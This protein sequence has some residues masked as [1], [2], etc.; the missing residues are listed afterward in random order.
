MVCATSSRLLVG[1]GGGRGVVDL[2]AGALGHP[3]AELQH[4]AP[5][6]GGHL[7]AVLAV[8]QM[9][10][11]GYVLEP[12]GEEGARVF[13]A[14]RVA[15]AVL[16]L[17]DLAAELHQPL[18][19]AFGHHGRQHGV[20]QRAEHA[21]LVLR[22]ELAQ[23]A[24]R[25]VAHAALRRGDGAQKGR[26]VVVVDPQAKP[27]AQ[28]ADLGAVK[29]R[30]AARDLVGDVGLAQRLLERLGLVVGAV[31]DGEV[32]PGRRRV[33][34]G[35]Q[36]LDARHGAL[37]LVLLVVA[38][39]HAHRLALAQFAEQRLG[40]QLGVRPDDVVGRAQ[41]GRGGAVVLLQ[42]D[43][44]ELRKVLRQLLQ[45]VQRGAAPA[46]DALVVVAHGGEARAFAH[47]EFQQLVL[48][49]VGVLVFI[50]QHM[51]QQ[52]LPFLAHLGVALQ[53]RMGMPIRSSKS[54]LW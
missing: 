10:L 9:L 27:G 19:P 5:A 2:P 28:V 39:H 16:Q 11:V 20:E 24:Q 12:V 43:D 52:A 32:L 17:V 21:L 18:Q 35:A 50:D 48:R 42:L 33:G 7:L 3:V 49:G 1:H 4:I 6:R 22:G 41:D 38:G 13:R 30:R 15:R 53:E 47:Q 40:E 34:G 31:Q 26:V 51:A 14:V 45:I 37:G 8:V 29:E 46:V 36:R 44:L 23:G 54:T 25:G